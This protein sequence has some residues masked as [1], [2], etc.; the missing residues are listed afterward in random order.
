MAQGNS[1]P[2]VPRSHSCSTYVELAELL[3][4]HM[5]N[6]DSDGSAV[7]TLQAAE[8]GTV[9]VKLAERTVAVE[10]AERTVDVELAERTVAVELAEDIV[11][12][13]LHDCTLDTP[14]AAAA[15]AATGQPFWTTQA[16]GPT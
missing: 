12:D 5:A 9:V 7:D 14:E 4:G 16:L 3:V 15:A 10:L 2:S 11:A 6:R 1:A 13:S 8:L